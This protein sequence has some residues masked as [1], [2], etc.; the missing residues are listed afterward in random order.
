MS[1]RREATRILV[2]CA[3]PD[4][5]VLGMGATI[6][7]HTLAGDRVHVLCL[8]EGSSAQYP[9][10]PDRRRERTD[11]GRRAAELLGVEELVQLEHPDERLDT[12]PQLELNRAIES[13]I[14]RFAP[15]IVYSV[16][17]DVNSDHRAVFRST[18]VAT[19]STPAQ[20][21]RRVLAFAIPSSIEWTPTQIASFAPTWFVDV[22]TTFERK[23][24]AFACYEIEARPY[25]HPRSVEGLRAYAAFHG[26]AA[27]CELAEPFVLVR[28]VVRG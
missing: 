21:V 2:V 28:N 20:S 4:D 25:P 26:A 19:R 23:L 13:Q 14:A 9:D 27:G 5:E 1:A 10:E 11:A 15:E 3:H 22:G 7:R 12:V 6:A 8:S 17:G 18:A 16:H 24:E